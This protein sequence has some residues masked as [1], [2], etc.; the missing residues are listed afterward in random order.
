MASA[1]LA[2]CA[3]NLT[4]PAAH[5]IGHLVFSAPYDLVRQLHGE[6]E[7]LEKT[8]TGVTFLH[9]LFKLLTFIR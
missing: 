9:V 1:F 8:A 3:Q 6:L 4:K 2:S 7:G 5:L